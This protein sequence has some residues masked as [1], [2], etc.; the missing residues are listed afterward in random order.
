MRSLSVSDVLCQVIIRS[1]TLGDIPDI[2][3]LRNSHFPDEPETVEDREYQ[4]QHR[5]PTR[6]FCQLVAELNGQ[7]VGYGNCGIAFGGS[8][9]YGFSVLV[10]QNELGRGIGRRLATA[11]ED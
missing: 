3:M 1:F 4:E 10:N 8:D 11:L 7:I 9:T 6:P 2:T 5:D